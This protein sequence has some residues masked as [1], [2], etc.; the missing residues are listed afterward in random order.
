MTAADLVLSDAGL[1]AALRAL[2]ADAD[3]VEGTITDVA[4]LPRF[5]SMAGDRAEP[6]VRLLPARAGVE[7]DF[8]LFYP[9]GSHFPNAAIVLGRLDGDRAWASVHRRPVILDRLVRRLRRAAVESTAGPSTVHE[10]S[11]D[12]SALRALTGPDE[13]AAE[14]HRLATDE[15]YRRIL[16]AHFAGLSCRTGGGSEVLDLAPH[17]ERAYERARDVLD[18]YGGVVIADSVGL[19]KT[20][21]GLRILEDT[22]AAGDRA[23]VVVPAALRPDWRARLLELSPTRP[24]DAAV[25]ASDAG[26]RDRPLDLW[27]K[28]EPRPRP[29]ILSTESL[30]RRTFD[31]ARYDGADLVLVD[32]AHHFRNPSTRRYRSLADLTRY[33]RIVML[34]ATPINN[35][36]RDLCHLLELFAPPGAFRHLGVPDYRDAFRDPNADPEAVRTVIS[37]CMI[38]RTR[39]FL[40]ERY[41]EVRIPDRAGR[42]TMHLRFPERLPPSP[43]PYDLA[44]TY[45]PLAEIDDWIV[46]LILPEPALDETSP[47]MS[48]DLLKIVLLKR[49]ESSVAAFRASILQQLAWCTTALRALDAGRTLTRPDYRATFRGPSDD[50]GSQLAFME[51]ILPPTPTGLERRRVF[52]RELESDR[53]LLTRILQDT[54]AIDPGVDDKLRRLRELVDGP[55]ADAKAIVFTEFRDTARYLYRALR[56]RPYRAL[57]HSGQARLGENPASRREVIERFAPRSNRRPDPPERER[58]KLLIATDVAS[59]G[60]NLQDASAVVSYDLPWN[61]VRLMQRVG[62]VD[63][64]GA[65]AE[66]IAVYHFVPGDRIE[67]LLGL[68]G[69]LQK[70]VAA[71]GATLGL[72]HPVLPYDLSSPNDDDPTIRALMASSRHLDDERFDDP[73]D[74]EEQAYL[75]FVAAEVRESADGP[76]AP[77][78]VAVAI[79][80]ADGPRAVS[81][82]Q[83]RMGERRRRLWLVYEGGTGRVVEDPAIAIETLRKP[84]APAPADAP[85]GWIRAAR[86]ALRRHV[87]AMALRLEALRLAGDAVGFNLPQTRLGK[88]IARYFAETADRMADAERARLDALLDRLGRRFTPATE[89]ALAR[90]AD[91]RPETPDPDFVERLEDMLGAPAD[92]VPE[93][94]EIREIGTLVV[95][96]PTVRLPDDARSR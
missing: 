5:R 80:A 63:R 38:R 66:H 91:Q 15:L 4:W 61:P 14:P 69:R 24:G 29:M 60:L 18:R 1:S 19:G 67:R 36:L 39:R 25:R 21:I 70:K 34:T 54:R 41:G 92:P 83:I 86:S 13:P 8:L 94:P 37:A 33:S 26:D 12:G 87:A 75:D 30:G 2:W 79:D 84:W 88:W 3:R 82:W 96:P 85:D 53:V 31:P 58:V 32:E 46:R 50:P 51:L 59:E 56:G 77:P 17:Q 57:I 11:G 20:Y 28:E 42:G 89:R 76:F 35:S 93:T 16:A 49:L 64:L 71:I 6:S 95:A 7:P 22:L 52:R 48:A 45:G 10:V 9:P 68:V 44:A 81:Y 27:V 47:S 78:L 65:L 40:R 55:L 72:D 73:L 23:L 43:V 90:L 74:P 62:R